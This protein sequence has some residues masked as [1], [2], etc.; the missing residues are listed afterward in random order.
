MSLLILLIGCL[1]VLVGGVGYLFRTVRG[2]EVI[3]PDQVET[4]ELSPV[5]T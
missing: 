5:A 1:G 4:S 3:L 2:V